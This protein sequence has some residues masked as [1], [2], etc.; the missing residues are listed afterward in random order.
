MKEKIWAFLCHL[1]YNMWQDTSDYLLFERDVW[2]E[3]VADLREAGCNM[4]VLDVG[5]GVRLDSH[6]EIAVRGSW[7]KDEMKTE[8]ARL[9]DMGFE[10]IPKLNFS[11]THTQWTGPYAR[12][13]STSEFYA[14]QH[15]VVC[16]VAE[17]FGRP[18]FFHIGYDEEFIEAQQNYP[19]VALRQGELWWHDL[20]VLC[21][22]VES[23]G[24]RPWM[25]SDYLWKHE[26]EFLAR[27]PR[28]VLQSNYFYGSFDET[29]GLPNAGSGARQYEILDRHGYEH[30]PCGYL[31]CVRENFPG[32][33]TYGKKYLNDNLVLGYM[34]TVWEPTTRQSLEK[35]RDAV[36][37]FRKARQVYAD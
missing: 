29:T 32:T 33:V 22:C 3:V 12:K 31:Q 17:L 6:P 7:T 1:G 2:E 35:Y 24:C 23:C 34:Q 26:E 8:L 14:F 19:Y 9:R 13:I 18:R 27:M 4:I 25:W 10:V 16:E 21:D 28:S 20:T 37:M 15:D 11:T 36:A 5:E 30:I